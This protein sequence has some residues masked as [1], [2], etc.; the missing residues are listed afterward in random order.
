M[1]TKY[2]WIYTIPLYKQNVIFQTK[3]C[4]NEDLTLIYHLFNES[5]TLT[6]LENRDSPKIDLL[7][8]M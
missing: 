4:L 7:S 8:L 2:D 1:K 5:R 6:G 3:A